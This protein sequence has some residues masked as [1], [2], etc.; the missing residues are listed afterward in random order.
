MIA[1]ISNASAGDTHSGQAVN[2]AAK[3]GSHT[4]GSAAHS[5]MASGQ[6]ASAAAAI[7]FAIF[8][9]VG[10]VSKHISADLMDVATRPIGKPLEI[11]DE[12]FIVGPPPNDAI[13]LDRI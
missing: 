5:I 13:K 6:V 8:G 10:E 9:S 12:S 4:S 11:S 7:P 2:H 1:I 3:S